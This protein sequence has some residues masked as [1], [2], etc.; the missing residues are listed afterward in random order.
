MKRHV[1]LVPTLLL[2]LALSACKPQVRTQDAVAYNDAIVDVQ[3]SVVDHFDGFVDAVDR[4]DSLGAIAALQHA[5]DTA[6]AASK[7][8]EAM[9]DFDGNIALRDASKALVDW[10]AKGLDTDFRQ[11]LPVLVSHFATLQQ[12]EHADSVRAAFSA[13]ED[14]L[15]ELL[16]KAQ[17]D[18]AATYKFDVVPT[19]APAL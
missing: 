9:P 8:L 13:E 18:F 17:M 14:H 2:L 7:K 15:F 6:R 4:S 12:L 11:V 1:S 10:Y 16:E 19:P 3:I 5:L